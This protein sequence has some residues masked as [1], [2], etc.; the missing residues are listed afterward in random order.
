[1]KV[2]SDKKSKK[3]YRHAIVKETKQKVKKHDL[4]RRIE[5]LEARFLSMAGTETSTTG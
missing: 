4:L 1:M 5:A 3:K 2:M